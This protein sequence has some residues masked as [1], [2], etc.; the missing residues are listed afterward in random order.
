[1]SRQSA[2]FDFQTLVL[3]AE[4]IAA[5][6]NFEGYDTTYTVSVTEFS[7]PTVN[8]A[9]RGENERDGYW[10]VEHGRF[11]NT[12]KGISV[13]FTLG[14]PTN[15]EFC[16]NW[17][18]AKIEGIYVRDGL[19]LGETMYSFP[20]SDHMAAEDVG[21]TTAFYKQVSE[22]Y[23]TFAFTVKNVKIDMDGL[24]RLCQENPKRLTKIEDPDCSI[25][26]F[27]NLLVEMVVL[28]NP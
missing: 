9:R 7:G 22:M 4:D 15:E 11:H 1:M 12:R 2:N 6:M 20:A 23:E 19:E 25:E 21:Q 13:S 8:A 18:G 26:E 14:L 10:I 27:N 24:I 17:L 5:R 28:C 3:F 16:E